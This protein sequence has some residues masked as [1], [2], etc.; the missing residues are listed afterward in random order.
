MTTVLSSDTFVVVSPGHVET[1]K[2]LEEVAVR[3]MERYLHQNGGEGWE[4]RS[5]FF[6]RRFREC[7]S[8]LREEQRKEALRKAEQ[9]N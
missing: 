1:F 4:E 5:E 7:S 6:Q 3:M 9:G 2:G 8:G